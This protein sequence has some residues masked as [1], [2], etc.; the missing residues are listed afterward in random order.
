MAKYVCTLTDV[1]TPKFKDIT[2]LDINYYE[3]TVCSLFFQFSLYISIRMA[4]H[5]FT[6]GELA[7]VC[8]GATVLFMEALSLTIARVC[9]DF[10]LF[11]YCS[12]TC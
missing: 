8:L 6:L 7:V 11:T 1:T 3:I 2:L 10:F 12:N 5:G 9:Y 4:H